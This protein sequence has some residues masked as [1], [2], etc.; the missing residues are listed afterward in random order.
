MHVCCCQVGPISWLG[1]SEKDE[2]GNRTYR[3]AITPV[4]L[5][6]PLRLPDRFDIAI[7]DLLK[8]PKIL[9]GRRRKFLS[10]AGELTK[11]TPATVVPADDEMCYDSERTAC[12]SPLKAD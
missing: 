8:R 5:Q 3:V 9:Q 6:N 1:P 7:E 2:S 4:E 10:N 11:V 12:Y